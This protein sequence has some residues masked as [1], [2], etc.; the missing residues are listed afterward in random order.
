MNLEKGEKGTAEL[1]HG[2]N[3]AQNK[4][5]S[6]TGGCMYIGGVPT[7]TLR[8]SDPTTPDFEK[9][10]LRQRGED[11]IT[12]LYDECFGR[13]MRRTVIVYD[14]FSQEETQLGVSEVLFG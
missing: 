10:P 3:T 13:S 6:G 7:T 14:S 8:F 5:C 9:D 1:R 11:E 2:P 12:L 4:D